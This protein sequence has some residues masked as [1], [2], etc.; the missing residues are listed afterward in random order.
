[1]T[2]SASGEQAH[3]IL[4]LRDRFVLYERDRARNRT[5]RE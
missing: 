2:V 3:V 1:M 4:I 5:L